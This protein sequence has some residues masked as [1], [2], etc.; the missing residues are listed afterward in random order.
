MTKGNI[1]E[2]IRTS[3]FTVLSILNLKSENSNTIREE[4]KFLSLFFQK[5][6]IAETNLRLYNV[7]AEKL[8]LYNGW[9]Y[10]PLE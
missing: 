6:V 10:I 3:H 7:L 8:K 2:I 1:Y 4:C 5:R 9:W